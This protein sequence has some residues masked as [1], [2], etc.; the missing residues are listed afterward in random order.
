MVGD[1]HTLRLRSIFIVNN[2][3][4]SKIQSV[5]STK[6]DLVMHLVNRVNPTDSS[7]LFVSNSRIMLESG[8]VKYPTTIDDV[9]S[10]LLSL[11]NGIHSAPKPGKSF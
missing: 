1:L 6:K 8:L 4:V 7:M 9:L 3:K 2:N 5:Y 10:L 11:Y